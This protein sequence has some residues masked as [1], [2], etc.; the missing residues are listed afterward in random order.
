MHGKPVRF[1]ALVA[2][3]LIACCAQAQAQ[4]YPVK[5]VTLV[6]PWPPGGPSDIVLRAL[7]GATEKHLGQTIVIENKPGASATLAPMQMGASGNPDGY[8]IVQITLPVFRYPFLRKT[9]VDPARDFSY[10]IGVSGYTLG[11]AVRSDAPWKTFQEFL[12]D[13]K[14]NP[15]KITYGTSGAGGTPH[16]TMEQIGKLN[17]ITWTHIPFKGATESVNA[18][19]GGH[20]H[21]DA[22][23]NAWAPLVN[24]GQFRLLVTWGPTRTT[25]WPTVPILKETGIDMVVASPYG[26]AGPKGM[27]PAIVKILHDAFRKGMEE[28][29]FIAAMNT[30]DQIPWYLS[31]EDYRSYAVRTLDEQK[32]IVEEFGLKLE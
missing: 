6:V 23:G 17:G 9:A 16:I 29:S 7:A 12:A 2:L 8:T 11:V 22:D 19:L 3:A 18:L 32:R 15:G 31:S 1:S 26:L 30:F 14:A 21:A 28:P 20:I 13:A 27:D 5:P 4:K 24:S 10:I 25:K